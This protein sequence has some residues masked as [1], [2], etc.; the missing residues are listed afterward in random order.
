MEK[1]PYKLDRK[2]LLTTEQLARLG[3]ELQKND[4]HQYLGF[5]VVFHTE[6]LRK[7]VW[8]VTFWAANEESIIHLVTAI[9]H[10]IQVLWYDM[11]PAQI[12]EKAQQ[13]QNSNFG[14]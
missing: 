7:N 10:V 11:T 3:A 6:D 8:E 9:S 1:F 14:V 12:Q 2:F 4:M 13:L 5:E